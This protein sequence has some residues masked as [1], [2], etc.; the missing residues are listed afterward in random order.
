MAIQDLPPKHCFDLREADPSLPHLDVRSPAEFAAGHPRGALNV[1]ISLPGPGGLRPN[2][3]FLAVAQ[4]LCPDPARR[5]ILSCA[6][7]GRSRRAAEALEAA[8]YQHLVNMRGGYSG[9]RGPDG[10]LIAQ[11][12]EGQG[13]PC[14]QDPG[15]RA[16]ETLRARTRLA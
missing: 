15:E 3:E 12:W 7:G 8:G 4:A 13:L 2:P 1:P 5:V 6:M 14:E 9:A 11:G 10:S 16:W